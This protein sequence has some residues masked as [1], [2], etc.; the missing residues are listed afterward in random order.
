M[1]FSNLNLFDLAF[2]DLFLRQLDKL[3]A[4]SGPRRATL[5]QLVRTG[6]RNDHEL[7]PSG[8]F[9]T[10]GHVLNFSCYYL[11]NVLTISSAAPRIERRRARSARTIDLRRSTHA[12]S[13][14][15]TTT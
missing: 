13:S 15:L 8:C 2:F 12:S 1:L 4:A 9:I 10:I 7:E 3:F 14:S 11:M 5:Q 6:T